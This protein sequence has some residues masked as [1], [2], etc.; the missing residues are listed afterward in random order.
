M[1]FIAKLTLEKKEGESALM[2]SAGLIGE[3]WG[4]VEDPSADELIEPFAAKRLMARLR[5]R[6]QMGDGT[7][8]ADDLEE[9]F[10][11]LKRCKGET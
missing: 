10:F 7:E 4:E 1:I 8:F 11:K 6:F 5:N 2:L 3:A 9:Y